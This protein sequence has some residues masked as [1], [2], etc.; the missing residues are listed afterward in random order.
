MPGIKEF[1]TGL[2]DVVLERLSAIWI[3]VSSTEKA[4]IPNVFRKTVLPRLTKVKVPVHA[5]ITQSYGPLP[6]SIVKDLDEESS[7]EHL[8]LLPR[9][10][11]GRRKQ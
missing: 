9:F 8:L 5:L 2:I 7:F 3:A 6:S 1:L 11:Y 10:R 4:T